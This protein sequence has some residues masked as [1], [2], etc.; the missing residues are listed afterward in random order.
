MNDEK[1]AHTMMT[2]SET[3]NEFVRTACRVE[4]LSPKP[5]NVSPGREFDDATVKDFLK[6]ADVIAPILTEATTRGIG[7]TIYE[8]VR[9]TREAVGHNTNLGI[10]LLLTPM[11]RVSL[12]EKLA[13]GLPKVLDGLTVEDAKWT[14]KA[15]ELASPGGLGAAPEQDVRNE[16]TDD[17]RRCMCLAADRD[18]IALQYCNGFKDVMEFVREWRLTSDDTED[19]L[20]ERVSRLALNLL[21]RFGD[22]LIAR[23]CGEVL[24]KTV[25]QMATDILNAD[26]PRTCE[27]TT[28][29]Q[30]FDAFLRADGNRRNPGTTA[31]MI[32]AIVFAGLRETHYSTTAPQTPVNGSWF[33]HADP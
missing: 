1:M 9:N 19:K 26:W 11:C 2:D 18:L 27:G 30:E 22:S 29:Y 6:S 32:A 28:L 16:P 13:D 14:Y 15:I 4:V 5:G 31:D 25:Q 12:S 8:A 17:L 3:L 21:S 10:I 20:H 23:K 7:E 24:S 33:E